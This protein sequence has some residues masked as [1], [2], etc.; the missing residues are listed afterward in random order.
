MRRVNRSAAMSWLNPFQ[1][2]QQLRQVWHEGKLIVRYHERPITLESFQQQTMLSLP[3]TGEWIVLNGGVDEAHSHSWEIHG[4]R[5]AYDFVVADAGGRRHRGSGRSLEDYFAYG[6]AIVAAADGDVV[7]IRDG[8]R[9]AP[10]VGTGWLD[11]QSRDFAGNSVTL[12]HAENE[13]TFSAHLVPGSIPVRVGERVA[14]GQVIGRCGNSGHSTEP[15]LHFQLQD[16]AEFMGATSLPIA[17]STCIVDGEVSAA[18]VRLQRPARVRP[19]SP[20]NG[21]RV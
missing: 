9:D 16:R 6:A 14:R 21:T 2:L 10:R 18:P 15:H 3:F 1:A 4:Q 19:A 12:R 11:W 8:V 5:Y 17:F 7:R 20:A 13:F